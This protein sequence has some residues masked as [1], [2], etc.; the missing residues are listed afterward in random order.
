MPAPTVEL[1]AALQAVFE[2]LLIGLL[3]GFQREASAQREKAPG[4]R[5]FILISLTGGICGLLGLPWLTVAALASITGLLAV[6][7]FQTPERTGITTEMAAVATFCLGFVTAV[8]GLRWGAPLAIGTAIVV[9]GFLEAKR[10]L[11]KLIR[12]T[13]TEAEFNDTLWFLAII[14]IIYPI[15]PAGEFGPY[16]FFA[17]RRVWLFVILISSISYIGYFLQKFLGV[18]RGLEMTAVLGGLASTTAAT[19]SFARSAREEGSWHAYWTATVIANSVHFPRVLAILYLVNPP[20][21]QAC[22]PLFL[23]MAAAGGLFALALSRFSREMEN[24]RHFMVGNPFRL[25]PALKLAAVFTAILLLT[26]AGAA[27]FGGGGVY[28]TSLLGGSVDVDA[29]ALSV[30]DLFT[31]A[32]IDVATARLAVLLSF[33]ANAVLKTGIASISTGIA[34][35][36]RVACG[37]LIMF[38]AGVFGWF[39]L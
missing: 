16:Y 13:I 36:L 25:A 23:A 19:A 7:H 24:K 37:F 5:D 26:K 20:L 2:A 14:F 17:P 22:V 33:A 35:G 31:S 8:P 4:V 34:Y 6:F 15:L 27:R 32:K 11:H 30:S 10:S 1:P 38:A 21:A 29:V 39:L 9:V 18:E 3:V 12:E 28:W